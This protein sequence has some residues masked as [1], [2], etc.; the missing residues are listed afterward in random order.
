MGD[1]RA[2]RGSVVGMP[3]SVVPRRSSTSAAISGAASLRGCRDAA[4]SGNR[5]HLWVEVPEWPRETVRWRRSYVRERHTRRRD[6]D[7]SRIS[8]SSGKL[9]HGIH[10]SSL[11]GIP[12]PQQ[13]IESTCS[14]KFLC[15]SRAELRSVGATCRSYMYMYM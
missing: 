14:S 8:Y 9:M 4:G 7:H 15:Q 11:D 6:R 5:L 13:S 1:P 12:R 2:V 10:W 3:V